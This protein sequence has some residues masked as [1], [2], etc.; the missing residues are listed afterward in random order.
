MI[1]KKVKVLIAD[2]NKDFCDILREYLEK[3]EDIEIVGIANNG[4]EA[5]ELIS[6]R[7]PDLVI[8][9]IIMPHLDGLGV[10]EQINQMNLNKFPKFIILSAV[11]QDKITQRAINLGAD[12]YIIKPFDFEIFIQRIRQMAGEINTVP[13][14][15]NVEQKR[16]TVNQNR[17]SLITNNRSLEAEITNIIHEIGVPA[18][19]KGYLY[20]REAI[21][22]VVENIEL[23]S[24]VTKELYPSIAKKFNTTSSRVERAIRHAIEVAW[25]RGKVDTINTLFGY[26][27]HNDKGK[28]TNSEF[29]AMV[30][31]KL[32][33]EQQVG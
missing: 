24:A 15:V 8:L 7:Q 3:Q 1:N 26:T 20:L 4:R 6:E 31:D 30:A 28:P 9:D 22:M 29:I 10:L 18:H 17:T 23:L 16:Q 32:R 5:V 13:T 33:I 25:S 11:G 21:T 2:D 19:I 12:Y 14:N 27:V